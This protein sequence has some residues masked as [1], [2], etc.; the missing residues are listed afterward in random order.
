VRTLIEVI[1]LKGFPENGFYANIF[2]MSRIVCENIQANM[3]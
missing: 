2:V 1:A 3:Y